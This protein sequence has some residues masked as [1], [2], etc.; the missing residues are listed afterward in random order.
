MRCEG[1]HKRRR[2]LALLSRFS[3]SVLREAGKEGRKKGGGDKLAAL[4]FTCGEVSIVS[5]E[6]R[7]VGS[8]SSL[9]PAEQTWPFAVPHVCAFAS[10]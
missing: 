4:T 6:D 7:A 1:R 5:C 3:T 8:P 9:A 2:G 10:H